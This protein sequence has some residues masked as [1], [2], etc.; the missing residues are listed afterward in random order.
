MKKTLKIILP[1]FILIGT[2]AL[3]M[4]LMKTK[5]ASPPLEISERVWQVDTMSVASGTYSPSITLYGKV[6]SPH[7]YNASAPLLSRVESINIREGDVF[8]KGQLLAQLDRRDF[9]PQLH[10]AEAKLAEIK[11]QISTEK[12]KYRSD[13]QAF[14]HEEKLL[15]LGRQALERS[16]KIQKQKLASQSEA[17]D[18]EKLVEQQRLS[19]NTRKLNLDGHKAR[20]AQLKATQ[21]Q[22][23][24][25]LEKAKLALE[26]ASFYAPYNGVV[27]KVN[28]AAGDQ[29]ATGGQLFSIYPEQGL[30]IRAKIPASIK[31][32]IR[33]D[34]ANNYNLFAYIL[35]DGKQIP[36]KLERLAG[37]ATSSGIDALFSLADNSEQLR[38]GAI[39]ELSLTRSPQENLFV[40]PYK[41]IYGVDKLY[42]V[43][44]DN[45]QD[46]RMQ[47][48]HM[49]K[50][51]NFVSNN[52][53]SNNLVSMKREPKESLLLIKSEELKDGDKIITTHLPN[54]LNGLKIKVIPKLNQEE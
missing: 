31:D 23:M 50:V 8:K 27:A 2:A 26:R 52:H 42:K 39:Y 49:L 29:L 41:S 32:E 48:I 35:V 40:V 16:L 1:I 13:K 53:N 12:L 47:A 36:L 11:A 30:E 45:N 15:Q 28:I 21:N 37:Q 25:E 14:K 46:A 33:Q 54:A 22:L 4:Y 44:M 51:G 3:V 10:I 34:L 5:A 7:L 18:A 38:L 24:A 9:L 43:H 19:L 20:M 6:E 17:D